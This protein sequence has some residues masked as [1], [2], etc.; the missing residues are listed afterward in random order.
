MIKHKFK[1]NVGTRIIINFPFN[2]IQPKSFESNDTIK[3]YN[4]KTGTIIGKRW[5]GEPCYYLLLDKP[6]YDF[7]KDGVWTEC[8]LKNNIVEKIKMLG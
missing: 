1:Y 6:P 7:T 2:Y 5:S 4:N 8:I 3:N